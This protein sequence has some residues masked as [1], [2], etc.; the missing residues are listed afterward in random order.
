[1][2]WGRVFGPSVAFEV[3]N[4]IKGYREGESGLSV[5]KKPGEHSRNEKAHSEQRYFDFKFSNE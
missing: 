4:D 2:N 5:G 1:M 3:G